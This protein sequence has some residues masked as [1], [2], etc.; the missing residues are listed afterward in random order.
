[1]TIEKKPNLW[2]ELFKKPWTKNALV[3]LAA[4][5]VGI[6]G[7]LWYGQTSA[8]ETVRSLY[9]ERIF[10]DV[11]TSQHYSLSAAS[12]FRRAINTLVSLRKEREIVFADN[13][14]TQSE[15]LSELQR[16]DSEVTKAELA[17]Q[18]HPLARAANMRTI[19]QEFVLKSNKGGEL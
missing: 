13:A 4:V 9:V 2:I 17:V 8:F 14:N 16:I 6:G 11:K 5:G 12:E 1:M 19:F 3:L 10:K 7:T 18:S 15:K